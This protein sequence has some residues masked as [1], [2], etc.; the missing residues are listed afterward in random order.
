MAGGVPVY[1][2]LRQRT[3]LSL[4][5]S[6]SDV[7][8]LDLDELES[9]ITDRT[10]VLLLNTPHNPTGKMF[11]AS[12]LDCIAKLARQHGIVVISDEVY[13]HIVFDKAR[14]PHLSMATFFTRIDP[15]PFERGQ[16]VFDNGLGKLAGLS[17]RKIWCKP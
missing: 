11:S 8:C 17:V 12:E 5:T 4:D 15:D 3:D 10:R 2:P 14:E 9:A 16:D 13:E 1:V 6:A 7:F